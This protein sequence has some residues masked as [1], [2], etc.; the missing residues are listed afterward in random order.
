MSQAE[1]P[2]S[3]IRGRMRN[4]SQKVLYGVNTLLHRNLSHIKL[5]SPKKKKKQN[6]VKRNTKLTIHI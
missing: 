6:K 3:Q 2:Q 4:T 5:Y 1:R